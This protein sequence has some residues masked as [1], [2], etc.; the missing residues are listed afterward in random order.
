MFQYFWPEEVSCEKCENN[1]DGAT[2]YVREEPLYSVC[3]VCDP[4][5]RRDA[6]KFA[7]SLAEEH[8]CNGWEWLEMA[9]PL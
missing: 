1:R 8:Y 2:F 6:V 7:S 5:A 9:K 3:G 4:V